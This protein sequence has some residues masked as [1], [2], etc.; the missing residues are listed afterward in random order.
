MQTRRPLISRLAVGR[1]FLR[2]RC[3][4]IQYGYKQS[5]WLATSLFAL[6]WKFLSMEKK[7]EIERGIRPLVIAMNNT[8]KL[9]TIGSCEGHW[10]LFHPWPPY[11][12]F[13]CEVSFA[14]R[15]SSTLFQYGAVTETLNYEWQL[16]GMVHPERGLCFHLS[17]RRQWFSRIKIQSDISLLSQIVISLCA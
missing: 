6:Y 10:K 3:A 4:T 15:L 11:V 7:L 12:Y 2:A 13:E 16:I 8:G 5:M 14:E 17:M 1:A 9:T